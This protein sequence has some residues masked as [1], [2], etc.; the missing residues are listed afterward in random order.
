MSSCC[1]TAQIKAN[2]MQCNL[3]ITLIQV[4]Q[5][6]VWGL[7]NINYYK[8]KIIKK[9]NTVISKDISTINN[10]PKIQSQQ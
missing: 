8:C 10:C 5:N 4:N 1:K 9:I 6:T 3:F 2:Y 7:F